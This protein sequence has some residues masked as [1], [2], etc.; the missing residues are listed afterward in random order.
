MQKVPPSFVAVYSCKTDL[1]ALIGKLNCW[2][3]SQVFLPAF[4]KHI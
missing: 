1:L 4:K 3:R 2:H